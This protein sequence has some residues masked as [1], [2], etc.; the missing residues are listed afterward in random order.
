M[1]AQVDFDG[2]YPIEGAKEVGTLMTRYVS[3]ALR[4]WTVPRAGAA[5]EGKVRSAQLAA[6]GS[7]LQGLL[8]PG[9][10]RQKGNETAVAAP[11]LPVVELHVGVDQAGISQIVAQEMPPQEHE[12]WS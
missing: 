4:P 7:K 5:P 1:R 3:R 11:R 12:R 10:G 2:D 8:R 6:V 9:K